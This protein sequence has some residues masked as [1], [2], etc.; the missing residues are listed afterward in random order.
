LRGWKSSQRNE[1]P[2]LAQLGIKDSNQSERFLLK[3]L[4]HK[5]RSIDAMLLVV[6]SRKWNVNG[7]HHAIEHSRALP[8]VVN[9][10]EMFPQDGSWSIEK[11]GYCSHP[12][13]LHR[14]WALLGNHTTKSLAYIASYFDIELQLQAETRE[15]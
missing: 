12:E 6:A 14:K 9:D 4:E 5:A 1:R 13:A 2:Q 15:Q 11:R 7:I 8:T 10:L 3:S